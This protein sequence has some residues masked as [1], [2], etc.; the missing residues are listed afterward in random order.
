MR[1]LPLRR[2]FA[3]LSAIGMALA[4]TSSAL[5]HEERQVGEYTMVVGFIGEPVFV[6]NRS[7]LELLVTRGD[8]PV[9]GL[10]ETLQAEVTYGDD[11]RELPLSPRF[12][13]AGAYQ[14]Y[15]IPTAAGPYTF[16]IFGTIDGMEVD[17][18]FTSSEDG[19]NEVQEVTAGQFP[20]RFPTQ[21]E[22]AAQAAS[23]A[24]AAGRVNVAMVL[25]AVAIVV[26]LVALGLSLARLRR[27]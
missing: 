14:S 24:E 9:D 2:L 19:F 20:V 21:A 12:G 16:H 15:F 13:E 11:T 7:G 27:S 25:G 4:F 8:T 23:G 10:E 18:R 22:L 5:A 3:A 1:K 6:G 17:E 26:A